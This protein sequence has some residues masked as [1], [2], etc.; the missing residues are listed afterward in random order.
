MSLSTGWQCKET[1]DDLRCGRHRGHDGMHEAEHDVLE[2]MRD[3]LVGIANHPHCQYGFAP[4]SPETEV[5]YSTGVTDG[6]RCAAEVAK[7][8]LEES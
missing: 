5:R 2:R 7:A 4:P 6:H 8:T 1:L 3:A